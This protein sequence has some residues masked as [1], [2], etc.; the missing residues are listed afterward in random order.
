MPSQETRRLVRKLF[1]V[2]PA[3]HVEG[4]TSGGTGLECGGKPREGQW[5]KP[6]EQGSRMKRTPEDSSS[7]GDERRP[8]WQKAWSLFLY[9]DGVEGES[10]NDWEGDLIQYRVAE[11]LCLSFLT[12]Q[13]G[14]V[15]LSFPW[16][17]FSMQP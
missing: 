4:R 5:R 17:L 13:N 14:S 6:K 15:C 3:E 7:I 1:R 12:S 9:S 8:V 11:R 16:H 2:I 10:A